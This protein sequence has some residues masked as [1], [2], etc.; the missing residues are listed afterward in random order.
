MHI[1]KS[2]LVLVS[3]QGLRS[4]VIEEHTADDGTS[5]RVEGLRDKADFEAQMLERIPEI[6]L[7]MNAAMESKLA[8]ENY[9]KAEEKISAYIKTVDLK[10]DVGLTDAEIAARDT[11]G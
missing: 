2:E 10:I 5:W 7:Q 6:E 1:V 11:Y 3:P 8:V 9:R 4:Y